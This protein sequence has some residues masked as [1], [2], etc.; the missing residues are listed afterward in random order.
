MTLLLSIVPLIH[1][2]DRLSLDKFTPREEYKFAKMLEKS[3]KPMFEK[4]KLTSR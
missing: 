1:R 2:K 3:K 4:D